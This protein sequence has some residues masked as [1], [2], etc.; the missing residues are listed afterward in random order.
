MYVVPVEVFSVT[1]TRQVAETLPFVET[2]VIV[3]LPG[4]TPLTVP[5]ASTVAMLS[6]ALDQVMP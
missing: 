6:F 2:A 4:A 3:V 1:V 5:L